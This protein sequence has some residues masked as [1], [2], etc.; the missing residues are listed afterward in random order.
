MILSL[1]ALIKP[2]FSS[3]RKPGGEFYMLQILEKEMARDT[4]YSDLPT[5][6]MQVASP[7]KGSKPQ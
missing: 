5:L 3:V 6:Q 2:G 1:P 7:Q 4:D